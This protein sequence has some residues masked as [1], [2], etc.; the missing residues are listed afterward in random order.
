MQ[1]LKK[2]STKSLATPI[3]NLLAQ[4]INISD[5]PALPEAARW[6]IYTTLTMDISAEDLS[7]IIKAN[8]SL[9]LKLLPLK[10][11][12]I[13]FDLKPLPVLRIVITI[14][15]AHQKSKGKNR[16]WE[17]FFISR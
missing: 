8:P 4:T 13:A 7:N 10:D 6:A 16:L 5:I 11:F 9:A 1:D 15:P 3:E 2:G 12:S 14:P 17:I